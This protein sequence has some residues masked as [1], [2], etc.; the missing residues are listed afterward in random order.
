MLNIN[1]YNNLKKLV[2]QR[3]EQFQSLMDFAEKK[4]DWLKAP[5]S[6][7]FHLCREGGLVE[8]SCNV[9]ETMLKLRE[10]LAPDISEESCVIVALLH[11]LGKAGMPGNPQYL[12]NESDKKGGYRSYTAPPYL[13]NTSTS[14]NSYDR[15][16]CSFTKHDV[17]FG[18]L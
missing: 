7:R 17:I 9:A 2:V 4:T 8:H 13:F 16:Q 12:P 11:D 15:F 10:V 18:D 5:A 1:R 6:T 3:G 14:T